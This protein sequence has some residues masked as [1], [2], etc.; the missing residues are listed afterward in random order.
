MRASE[1]ARRHLWTCGECR[2]HQA[3]LRDRP[4]RLRRLAGWSPWAV[5]AQLLGGG[6]V[7]TVQ[8]V[9]VGACC[10]LVVGGGAVTV[11]VVK[12]HATEDPAAQVAMLTPDDIAAADRPQRRAQA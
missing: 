1:I 8:K 6:G 11:P 9:A 10:A 2:A 5:V 3:S 12:H 7:A 4:S